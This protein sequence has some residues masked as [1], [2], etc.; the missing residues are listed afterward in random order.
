MPGV[1]EPSVLVKPGAG[2]YREDGRPPFRAG[3]YAGLAVD[4]NDGTFWAAN[5]Y[6]RSTVSFDWGT[7]IGNFSV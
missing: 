2:R 3:D 5:E 6:D 7:W 4:P 1:L